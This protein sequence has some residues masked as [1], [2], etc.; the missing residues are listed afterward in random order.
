[1]LWPIY[2]K[3]AY[4]GAEEDACEQVSDQRFQCHRERRDSLLV[5][6]V[7]SPQVDAL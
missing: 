1:M 6:Y 5:A 7:V 2:F 3:T 4:W